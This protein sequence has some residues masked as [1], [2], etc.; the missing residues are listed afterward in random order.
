MQF[1]ATGASAARQRTACAIVGIHENGVH[2]RRRARAR[3]R[4]RRR[5]R[6]RCCAAA[7]SPARPL[8]C[9]RS[10]RRAADPRSGCCWSA[11]GPT[12]AFGRKAY[13]R[14]VVAAT[15]WLAKSGATNA[16][17]YLAADAVPGLEPYY[18]ARQAVESVASTLYR[19]NDLKSGEKAAARRSSR[20]SASRC[21]TADLAAARARHR[22]RARHRRRHGADARPRQP[23]GERLH[24]DLSRGRR[25]AAREGTQER[26][27]AR[28]RRARDPAPG[29][30]LVPVGDARLRRAAAAHRARVPRAAARAKR[31]SRWSARASPSTPA[32]FR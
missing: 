8:K 24:A 23:A 11:S 7:I 26:A 30:G 5:D 13:R 22:G 9:C 10:S 29:D 1:H 31:R 25:A 15:Q 16:V 14:A 19:M 28:A 6:A 2:D 27:R 20:A 4:E 17:S 18:A 3:S 21:R 32:A 12:S